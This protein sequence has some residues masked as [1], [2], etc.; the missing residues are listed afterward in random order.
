MVDRYDTVTNDPPYL[1]KN[2]DWVFHSDFKMLLDAFLA[3]K[4]FIDNTVDPDHERGRDN[5]YD[6]YED[7]L[8][9]VTKYR[10]VEG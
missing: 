6:E 1:H 10:I 4:Y 8:K 3:A 9:I 5:G 2:G 7:Y